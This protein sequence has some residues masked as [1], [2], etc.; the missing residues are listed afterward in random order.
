[1][2]NEPS[3]QSDGLPADAPVG[4]EAD[5]PAGDAGAVDIDP[6][7]TL[8]AGWRDAWQVPALLVG[9][10]M[11]LLG[12]AFSIAKIPDPDLTPTITIANRLIENED[13]DQAIEILNTK[14]YPF[15]TKPEMPNEDKVAYHLAIARSVYRGQKKLHLDDDRNHVSVIREYLEAERIGGGLGPKDIASLANTYIARDE[16]DQAIQRAREIPESQR[17][18][19]DAVHRQAVDSMLDRIAPETDKAMGLLADML[20]DPNLPIADRVWALEIQ[21]N[22]RLSQGYADETI[23]RILRAM[24]RLERAGVE[25]RSRL[26][27]ILSKA[28]NQLGA[29]KQAGDQV[30]YAQ[31][32]S[33]DGDSHYPEILL[34]E[35]IIED[36]KGNTTQARDIYSEITS[37][38]ASS[39]AM[40]LALLGLGETEAGL[41]EPVL[42]FEAFTDLIEQYD[43]FGIE[44]FPSRKQILDS[45]LARASDSLS[46]GSADDSI[47]YAQLGDKLYRGFDVPT[48]VLH[49]LA[50]GHLASA[51][52]LLGKPISEVPSLLGLDPSTRAEVQRHL[53]SSATNYQMHADRHLVTNLPVFADS[54]WRSADLFDRAGDQP[55]AIASFKTY[56]E[57]MP[58]DPR[59]A[60]ALFRLGES[61]RALGDF[62]AASDVYKGLIEDRE[63]SAGADIGPFAD[64][65]HVPLAQ[66]FLYDEDPSND[67][68]AEKLLVSALNGSMG[69]TETELFR[70]AL[71]ELA[72][73]YDR[74]DR[75]ERAIERYDEFMAR[76]SN[77]PEAGAVVFKLADA[78]RRLSDIIE[79]S[80]QEAMPAAEENR[81]IASI[82]RH[83][84][85]AIEQYKNTISTLGS[86]SDAQLGLF[87]S[88]ALR[89]AHFYLGDCAFDLGLFND[90]IGYYDRARDHYVSDPAS[91]VAMIQI[92]N[93][94]IET[95][96]V[97]RARTA[98]DRARRFYEAIPDAAWDDPNLP[99]DRTDW[100]R[101][102]RS[103]A[104][105][106]AQTGS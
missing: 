87:E 51:E 78:H 23:T 74:T 67:A 75:P 93:A 94:Y 33:A 69:S 96:Q 6:V 54:L 11:L 56:A 60:E 5:I 2:A 104:Q 32:L 68:E 105:L 18:L 92:V 20:I 43:S 45:L 25:G 30:E 100:E 65:S 41:N 76:Y 88:I 3:S 66:A 57:S 72:G 101:W 79:D 77:D 103:S 84:Y 4:V 8:K 13:Y 98:N 26:H 42:A 29:L 106:L 28:Y 39:S 52:S 31:A 47:H 86:K 24:P 63:G 12:V 59:H 81:R 22:V 48:G 17:Y 102:L 62:R 35:A 49:A 7:S 37:N 97:G 83:R 1:M 21:G 80:L 95:N 19:R 16:I 40:P 89:N 14:I 27:L 70:D 55:E 64:A 15:L 91:L 90:A 44:S 46:M 34:M 36:S 71:L 53:I 50:V 85:E 10:G 38:Y 99:M 73:L 82:S 61:L 9:G 58:S